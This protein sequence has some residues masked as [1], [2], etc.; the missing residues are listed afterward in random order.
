MY[1][2]IQAAGPATGL[3]GDLL[4]VDGGAVLPVRAKADFPVA[5][6]GEAGGLGDLQGIRLGDVVD[7]KGGAH[8]N[9]D[10]VGRLGFLPRIPEPRVELALV[11]A[12]L[13]VLE[14]LGPGRLLFHRISTAVQNGSAEG[15]RSYQPAHGAA[16]GAC[17]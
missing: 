10:R 8:L 4:R 17:G 12:R 2:G 6:A 14:D 1:A 5:G 13:Q 9:E 3:G 11:D 16:K 15:A 7:E